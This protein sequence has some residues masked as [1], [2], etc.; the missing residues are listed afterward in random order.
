MA[1]SPKNQHEYGCPLSSYVSVT[2]FRAT[3]SNLHDMAAFLR[4]QS[5]PHVPLQTLL[6]P[7][8]ALAILQC[9]PSTDLATALS[10]SGRFPGTYLPV[11]H[12]TS[13]SN[14][15]GSFTRLCR[16]S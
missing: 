13:F 10:H 8:K 11:R 2:H 9:T 6:G 14:C 3:G 4:R 16:C 5:S 12:A 15:A 1:A 7:R